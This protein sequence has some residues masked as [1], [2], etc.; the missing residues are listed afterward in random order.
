MQ[1]LTQDAVICAKNMIMSQDNITMMY[2][3]QI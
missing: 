3:K 1:T 2:A